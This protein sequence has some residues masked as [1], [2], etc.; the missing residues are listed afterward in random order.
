MKFTSMQLASVSGSTGGLT[1][2]H[3]RGGMYTRRRAVPTDPLSATQQER[4]TQLTNATQ[5]WSGV[6]SATQRDGWNVYAATTTFLDT[7]GQA[8]NYSGMN[9]FVRACIL[10]LIAAEMLSALE[11]PISPG[12]AE[13]QEAAPGV[14][15]SS[16]DTLSVGYQAT[17]PWHSVSGGRLLAFISRPLSAGTYFFKGP[18]RF[19]GFVAGATG[20]GPASPL[21]LTAPFVFDQTNKIGL[22]L[23]VLDGDNKVSAEQRFLLQAGA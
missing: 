13:F 12:V 10:R 18:Y 3:N 19:A 14:P 9:C 5:A 15:D 20:G 22:R 1:W 23:I 21:V 17:D 6:L 8:I 2:S 16:A 4:R 11:P 7:L